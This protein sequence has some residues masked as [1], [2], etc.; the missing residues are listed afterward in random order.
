MTLTVI[1]FLIS[2]SILRLLIGSLFPVTADESYYWLWSKHLA[3]SFVDHPPMVA[4]V[5]FLFTG[6]KEN[7]L[8]LRFGAVVVALL[9]SIG[10]YS[11]VKNLLDEKIAALSVVLFQ[12]IPHYFIIWL[13]MFVDLPLA[14]FWTLSLLIISGIIKEKK[15]NLWYLLGISVGLG[16]LSKYTM[17][18]FWAALLFFFAIDKANRFWLK[19]KEFYLSIIIS[20]IFFLPVIIWNINH[21]FISFTFHTER[22]SEPFGHNFLPYLG[23]QLVHFT[24]ILI[25]VFILSLSF[26]LKKSWEIRLLSSFSVI[27]LLLF[28]IISF[29][30]KVWAHWPSIGYVT[31]IPLTLAYLQEKNRAKNFYLISIV[32]FTCL[33]TTLLLFLPPGIVFSQNDFTENYKIREK[34]PKGLKIFSETGTSASIL[35]F[36]TKEKV[37]MATGFMKP[38]PIV[39]G[40]KQFEIW[41]IPDLQKGESIIF[42]GSESNK[43]LKNVLSFFE[44]IELLEP[45]LFL[46]EA[47]ISNHRFYRMDGFRGKGLHP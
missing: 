6:G 43:N 27:P 1:I 25:I 46:T 40:E 35:E 31:A 36:Y 41:G 11:L 37:Y 47:Y 13:T 7:L 12:L 19:T 34:L 3:L 38:A 28:S 20:S 32:A 33:L 21:S 45:K 9:V 29:K 30:T 14:L 26:G 2:I 18:L 23:D 17:I 24:P 22:V 16:L 8:M 15:K 42:Y 10:I 5:N 39:W 44:K 4:F